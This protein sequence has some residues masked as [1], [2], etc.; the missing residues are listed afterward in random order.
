VCHGLAVGHHGYKSKRAFERSYIIS[1][2]DMCDALIKAG[3]ERTLR[4]RNA[5][6]SLLSVKREKRFLLA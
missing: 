2:T 3:R 6:R 1:T 4:F 5:E